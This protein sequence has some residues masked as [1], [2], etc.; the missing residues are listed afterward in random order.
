MAVALSDVSGALQTIIKP[1]VQ[2]NFPKETILLDKFKRNVDVEV[3]NNNF[4]APVRT[5]RHSGVANLAN[6]GSKLVSGGAQ[7]GQASV[8]V[9]ILTGTFD[10][11]KLTIDATSST[12]K[13]VVS[14][15]SYQ[16]KTL[17]TDFARQVNRQLYGDGVGVVSEVAGS[18][19]G[20]AFTIRN[21][22]ASNDDGR[23][24]DNYGSVNGDINPNKYLVPGQIIG[25]GTA[26]AGTASI[27]AVS[28]STV[29]TASSVANVAADAIYLVDG[30][31]AGAGT[32]EITGI[33]A[34]LSSST[35]TSTYAGLART[36]QGWA[37]AIGTAS[38]ALTLSN[39]ESTY[40]Q[41]REYGNSSDQIM[42]FV[43]KTLY[44]KYG[45]LLT[46]LRRTVNSMDLQG[47]WTGLE[48]QVGGGKVA[49][50]LDYDVPDGEVLF[51]NMDTWTLCQV[52]DMNWAEDPNGGALL[53][54]TDYLTYQA[55]MV[56]FMNVLC[57]SPAANGRLTQK[58]A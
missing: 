6:G 53:R 35:G 16:A 27:V 15:M 41:A 5:R 8:G 13:S 42:I 10:I 50:V 58:T 51:L 2:D 40:L 55:T 49:V 28:G 34:A 20:T 26:G 30:D 17:T 1:F 43:N 39:M 46:A 31:G 57:V 52:S 22:S 56:W 54:R 12:K 14:Q 7:I 9:K 32:S 24:I 48:F 38:G 33:R 36:T 3:F 21:V 37:P 18:T 29:T 23:T 44:Q 25:I 19:S 11:Q 45:D 4:Y 47:G